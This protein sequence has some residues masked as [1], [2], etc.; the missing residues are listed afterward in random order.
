M[1]WMQTERRVA[2]NPQIKPVDLG[3][4]SAKNW[5]L[6]P[7]STIAIV[8]IAQPVGWY[9]CYHPMKGGRLSRPRCCSK[10]AIGHAIIFLW[11]SIAFLIFGAETFWKHHEAKFSWDFQRHK[12]TYFA[13]WIPGVMQTSRHML[14]VVCVS[15]NWAMWSV[16]EVFDTDSRKLFSCKPCYSACR[17]YARMMSKILSVTSWLLFK[18]KVTLVFSCFHEERGRLL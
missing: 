7:T 15:D 16:E 6:P 8:I 2:A 18:R 1:W 11:S 14:S 10:C 5:Q 3:C 4:E 13:Y 9:S 17:P 12:R